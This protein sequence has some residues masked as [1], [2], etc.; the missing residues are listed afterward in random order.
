MRLCPG[1]T[2]GSEACYS[3]NDKQADAYQQEVDMIEALKIAGSIA[4]IFAAGLIIVMG[5]AG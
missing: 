3:G 1:N 2:L 5:F 4:L